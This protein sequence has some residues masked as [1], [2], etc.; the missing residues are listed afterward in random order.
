MTINTQQ[1]IAMANQIRTTRD[2]E[3]LL[4]II[5]THSSA[6]ADLTSSISTVQADILRD[7][8][9]L[10]TMPSPTPQAIIGY[11]SKLAVGTAVPQLRAQVK[12]TVQLGELAAAINEIRAAIAEAQALLGDLSV[13]GDLAEVADQLQYGIADA[14][15]AL[16]SSAATSLAT[17]A[18]TQTALNAAA[19]TTLSN[20]DTSSIENFNRT[21]YDEIK[22]LDA[23]TTEFVALP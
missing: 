12:L 22:N 17:V 9:P 2:P 23:N 4:L 15:T 1:I 21:A 16:N 7:I 8:L 13:V 14:I 18:Q 10:L 3:S 19:N 20:F 5:G 11:L 6:I